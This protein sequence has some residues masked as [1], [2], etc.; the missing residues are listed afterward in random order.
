MLIQSEKLQFIDCPPGKYFTAHKIIAKKYS[1]FWEEIGACAAVP[2][3]CYGCER[4]C[5]THN[6]F[7]SYDGNVIRACRAN[8]ADCQ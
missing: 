5:A 6:S 1:L 8:K 3:R 2:M 4:S 7:A